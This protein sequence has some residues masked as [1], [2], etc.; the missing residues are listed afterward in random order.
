MRRLAILTVLA[1]CF[2]EGPTPE[3][4]RDAKVLFALPLQPLVADEDLDL[5]L[6]QGTTNLFPCVETDTSGCSAAN[7]SSTDSNENLVKTVTTAGTYY[8]VVRG[9]SGAENLYDLCI[10]LTATECPNL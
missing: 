1:G 6:F 7:G 8:V 9:W 10:G 2:G 4:A 5:Q 3:S